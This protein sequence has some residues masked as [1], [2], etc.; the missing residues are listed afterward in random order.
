MDRNTNSFVA[1]LTSLSIGLLLSI[2][3]LPESV[4]PFRPN[5]VSCILLY[6]CLHQPMNIG[7]I[8]A[9]VIGLCKDILLGSIL[10]MHVLSNAVTIYLAIELYKRIRAFPI[11]KQ[12]MVVMILLGIEAL[13]ELQIKN[14]TGQN[15]RSWMYWMPVITSGLAWPVVLFAMRQY[16]KYFRFI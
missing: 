11:W 14:F 3:P 8:T 15:V 7:V 1:V 16:L 5:W 12:S 13:I 6:W 2:V 9:G 4:Q 10:G